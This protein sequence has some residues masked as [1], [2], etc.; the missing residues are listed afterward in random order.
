MSLTMI[1]TA[2][3]RAHLASFDADE[4][5]GAV[6][7]QA[8]AVHDRARPEGAHV[9]GRAGLHLGAPQ[10]NAHVLDGLLNFVVFGG[11]GAWGGRLFV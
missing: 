8:Q 11:G 3:N 7:G 1:G 2:I 5:L 6:A 9:E 10:P 4:E